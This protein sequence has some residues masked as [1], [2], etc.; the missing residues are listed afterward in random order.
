V[1]RILDRWQ[2]E[3]AA[4]GREFVILRVPREEVVAEPLAK[5]DS[6]AP[7]LHAYC[8]RRNIPLVDPTSRFVPRIAAGEKVYYDHY[9]ALGH[10]LFADAFVA[11]WLTRDEQ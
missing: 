11:Y 6:W 3:V 1:E 10:R 9:T 4:E 7:R 2:R 8:E 5:Q